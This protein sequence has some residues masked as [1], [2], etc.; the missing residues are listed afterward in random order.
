MAGRALAEVPLEDFNESINIMVHSWPGQGKT[1][2]GS[3]APNCTLV[4]AEPGSISAKR[5]GSRAGLIKIP[6]WEDALTLRD[7]IERG[8]FSHR[9]WL[10]IDTVSTIQR[11]DMNSILDKAVAE[12]PRRDPDIPAI[13]DYQKQQNSFVRWMERL[14]D[15]PIN[16][17]FLAHTM[18]VEDRDGTG[19]LMPSIMGGPD[20]GYPIANYCMGLMN[21]VGY[22]SMTQVTDKESKSKRMVRRILWQPYHDAEKDLR[23]T[24]KDQFDAFGMF[25]DD[26]SFVEHLALLGPSAPADN[27]EQPTRR[28]ATRRTRS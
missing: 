17:L 16:C 2:W 24:A 20:K 11:K 3:K 1:V 19:M 12:N 7:M 22:M 25:T 21:A 26:M 14:V 23:Y 18:H 10:V 13:Q 9:D 4:S 15:A 6:T 5:Q 28:A 27:E 8:D